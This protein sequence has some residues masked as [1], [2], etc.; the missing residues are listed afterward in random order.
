MAVSTH[1]QPQLCQQ[2]QPAQEQV[3]QSWSE[4][5]YS[6]QN[7]WG[8]HALSGPTRDVGQGT[9]LSRAAAVNTRSRELYASYMRDARQGGNAHPPPPPPPYPPYPP[10]PPRQEGKCSVTFQHCSAKVTEGPPWSEGLLSSDS[11]AR[12]H[13]CSTTALG[14]LESRMH[15][16]SEP[17]RAP[18]P[19]GGGRRAQRGLVAVD[20]QRRIG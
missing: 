10:L 17:G 11:A 8:A 20:E 18:A 7:A 19:L 4:T 12:W 2:P 6:M 5:R 1:P 9:D 15:A 14:S 13:A 3:E 16:R